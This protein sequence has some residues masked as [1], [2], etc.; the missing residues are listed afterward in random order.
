MICSISIFFLRISNSSNLDRFY[1]LDGWTMTLNLCDSL[2]PNTF[3]NI[4]AL[5]KI[6]FFATLFYWVRFRK[7][8]SV[9]GNTLVSI[10]LFKVTGTKSTYI[11]LA[12]N[13]HP[14]IFIAYNLSNLPANINHQGMWHLSTYTHD[15]FF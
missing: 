2:S 1:Y 5:P 14:Q 8:Q 13:N 15:N 3:D 10:Q 12:L 7:Y 9:S 6:F 4:F 11:P